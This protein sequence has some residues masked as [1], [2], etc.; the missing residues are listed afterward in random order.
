VRPD[1]SGSVPACVTGAILPLA[2]DTP[3]QQWME[4]WGGFAKGFERRAFDLGI[5]R[6]PGPLFP[7]AIAM[8]GSGASMLLRR[9]DA[10]ALGG[11][12]EALGGGTPAGSGEDLALLLD[13]V[14]GGG[15]IL[16]EPGA[17]VW[18]EHASTE[19]QFRRTLRIYGAGLTGYLMRHVL[20]HPVAALRI[21]AAVPAAI[22]Y[23]TRPHQGRN[24]HRT[25]T[26]PRGTWRL[27]LV[28]MLA[29]PF[30]YLAGRV[31]S[32]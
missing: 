1:D 18:H 27:E 17:I 12:D 21:V 14:S 2:L 11:F 15:T 20:R 29:G 30:A 5:H 6:P 22:A 24:R 31:R 26:F 10:L 28:G 23:A 3:A 7:Y 13:V 16:Y 4:E 8:C 32:R 19:R 9:H 25:A